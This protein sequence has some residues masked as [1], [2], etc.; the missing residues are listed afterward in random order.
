MGF[1]KLIIFSFIAILSIFNSYADNHD[2]EQNIIEKAKEINQKVKEKQANQQANISSEIGQEEPLP[3]NDPF[4]GDSS[5]TGG[6]QTLSA[7][8]KE[9]KS[10]MSLYNFKLVGVMASASDDG[11]ASLV[12]K[13]GNVLTIELFEELSPGVKLVAL[14]NKEAVF[15]KD[16]SLYLV[17]NFKNQIIERAKWKLDLVYF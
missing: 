10:E 11:F 1:K 7:N 2:T 5:F 3:L 16:E 12:N 8:S 13:D 14:N 4:I 9:A 15:E 6:T 17:I